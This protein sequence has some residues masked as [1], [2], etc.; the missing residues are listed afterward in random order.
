MLRRLSAWQVMVSA[1]LILLLAALA[2]AGW[3]APDQDPARHAVLAQES[4]VVTPTPPDSP[5]PWP[6]VTPPY[7]T[8][9]PV[10]VTEIFIPAPSTGGLPLLDVP[11]VLWEAGLGLVL[12]GLG[13]IW[14]RRR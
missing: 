7:P 5:L 4:P 3:A 10:P 6:T 1:G 11:I 8:R 14:R 12:I 2:Q 13:L 9:T